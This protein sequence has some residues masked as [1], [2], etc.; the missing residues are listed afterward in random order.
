MST[1]STRPPQALNHGH[2]KSVRPVIGR[3]FCCILLCV[4]GIG[5]YGCNSSTLPGDQSA[6]SRSGNGDG[7]QNVT[8]ANPVGSLKLAIRSRHW[9]KAWDAAEII[10]AEENSSEKNQ[11]NSDDNTA[12]GGDSSGGRL[13]NIPSDTLVLIAQAAHETGRKKE[14]AEYLRA[15]CE[16]EQFE[17]ES[18]VRQ[19]II[20]MVGVGEFYDGFDFLEQALAAQPGQDETRRWLF[21]FYVGSDDRVSAMPHGQKLVLARKFDL[22]LLKDLSNTERRNLEAAPLVQMVQRNPDDKR[23][24]LGTAKTKFDE[25]KYDETIDIIREIIEQHPDHQPSQAVLGQ[26]LAASRRFD[27]LETWAAEQTDGIQDYPGYWIALGDWAR[28]KDD[29]PAALRCFAEAANCVDPDVVQIWTR[30]AVLLPELSETQPL[31]TDAMISTVNDRAQELNRFHQLKDRF[32]R[33]GDISRAIALDIA[34]ML[35][36]LGRLWEAEAWSAIATTLPEDDSVDVESFRNELVNKLGPETPWRMPE[37]LPEFAPL[38]SALRLP[39]IEKVVS[40][41]VPKD[42]SND[43]SPQIANT[44]IDA[45]AEIV[46][47]KF[48]NEA[49]ARGLQF[50]GRTGDTLDQAGIMLYQTLGCGGGAIDFDLDGWSDLYLA[51]AGGTPP[52]DDSRP[53]ELFRNLNG[54]FQGV[55]AVSGTDDTGFGQGVAVGDVNED[56]F[57]D[58]L[59]LN[60]GPNRLFINNGDGTFTDRSSDIQSGIEDEW[61]A[62]AAIADLDQDGLSDIVIVNYCGTLGPINDPCRISDSAM[63]RSCSPMLF[64]ALPDQFFKANR[65]GTFVDAS[66]QW[67]AVS[68]LPGRGLGIVIGDLDGNVGNEVFVAND[69]TNNHYWS[70][71]QSGDAGHQ[72]TFTESAMLRGIGAD[73]RGI[74]Q[75]SMGIASGDLDNDGDIDFYVTNFDKEYNTLHLQSSA[76]IWQDRTDA[77]GLVTPTAP[78]VGFGTEAIDIDN[79]GDLELVLTNGHVDLFSRGDLKVMYYQPAQIFKRSPNGRYRSVATS[80]LGPY[81]QSNHAGRGLWTI[82]AD[83][84]G[85]VD[86]LVTHQTEPIALMMNHSPQSG[87]WIRMDLKG[88]RSSRSAIGSTVRVT[89]SQGTHTAFRLAGDGYM[90]SNDSVLHVGLGNVA[91]E[92]VTLTVTWPTGIE[93]RYSDVPTRTETVIVE[94]DD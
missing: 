79:S 80:S 64:P 16:N 71:I 24:M 87:N 6:N 20:A 89:T 2:D 46:D 53:N 19:T 26:A 77:S 88:R 27:E 4:A 65:D 7:T 66:K 32:T 11:D 21:D 37:T 90:C 38:I 51:D 94:S 43:D 57:P 68:E 41:S 59:V 52:H 93:E 17:N 44:G 67:N 34:K 39:S 40:A 18:R 13:A 36:G 12:A 74:P 70:R 3:F 61:S 91:D 76:G 49:V 23:P 47:W 31:V 86:F 22:V 35:V 81:F 45:D 75:G 30:L 42:P 62:S 72:L 29:K 60:Y 73:D 69:M 55:A 15:A 58:L 25:S 84:N 5:L 78:L 10:L 33:T 8:L 14:A 48:E 82:D 83:R 28:A 56:G 50:W 54:H 1:N 9:G 63:P 92:T 85:L